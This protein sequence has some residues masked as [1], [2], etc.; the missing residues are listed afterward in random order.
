MLDFGRTKF[1]GRSRD[2]MLVYAAVFAQCMACYGADLAFDC[3]WKFS[4][5]VT[6]IF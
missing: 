4:V 1:Q 5:L 2:A 3:L 6:L